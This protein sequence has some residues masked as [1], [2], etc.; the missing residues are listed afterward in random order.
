[1]I[2]LY[3]NVLD[4]SHKKDQT[5]WFRKV[6]CQADS[7]FITNYFHYGVVSRSC[8]S[9]KQLK[10]CTLYKKKIG[11]LSQVFLSLPLFRFPWGFHLSALLVMLLIG[12]CSAKYVHTHF[13][14]SIWMSISWSA[15]FHRFSFISLSNHLTFMVLLSQK[16]MNLLSLERAWKMREGFFLPF[17]VYWQEEKKRW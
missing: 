5:Y 11:S 4:K 14:F 9:T 1:M 17:V 15:L 6:I 8:L 3:R 12:F 10:D 13:L 7:V 16:L 2:L